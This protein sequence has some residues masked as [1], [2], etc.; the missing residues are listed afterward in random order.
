MDR[1]ADT[2]PGSAVP[3]A[4]T[5]TGASQKEV[6]VGIFEIGLQQIMIDVL[7]REFGFDTI[8]IHRFQFQHNH[9]AGGILRERLVDLQTYFF[10]GSHRSGNQMALDKFMGNGRSHQG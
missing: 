2:I 6:V 10:P 5:F 9:G 7:G 8:E 1:V 3:E 4:K